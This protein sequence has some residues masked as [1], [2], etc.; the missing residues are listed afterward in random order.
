MKALDCV[1][2]VFSSITVANKA[3]KLAIK[4]FD[5][6]SVVQLPPNLGI[7]GCNYCLRIK[8]SD[9]ESMTEISAEH[10]LKIK[11]VYIEKDM[12]KEKEYIKI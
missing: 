8:K 11:A 1:L 12:G 7:R 6:A 3:K 9:Y 2:V 10:K 4:N 5:Y